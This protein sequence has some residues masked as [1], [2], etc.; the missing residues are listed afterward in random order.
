MKVALRSPDSIV[1]EMKAGARSAAVVDTGPQRRILVVDDDVDSAEALAELLRDYG[2]E[3]ATAHAGMP[4]IDQARLHRPEI[5]LLDICMPEMDGYEVAKRLR[6]EIGL[7]DALI[8]ALT[9]YGED[10]D[11]HLARTAGF[12]QHVT[13][14]VDTAKLE[15]LLKLPS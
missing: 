8:V 7:S 12:D 5:V 15:E 6:D 10:R 1:F 2:H 4:A 11:R 13:K 14:P 9:G 3:V